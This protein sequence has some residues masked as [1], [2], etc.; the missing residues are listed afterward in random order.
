LFK[1]RH[2]H[3]LA[4]PAFVVVHVVWCID[5]FEYIVSEVKMMILVSHISLRNMLS[6]VAV[7][8]L[9]DL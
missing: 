9:G 1:F 4:L 8:K 6:S 5:S 2:F 7:T 3:Q